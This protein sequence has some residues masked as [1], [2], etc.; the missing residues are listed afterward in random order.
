VAIVASYFY[1]SQA[2]TYKWKAVLA[3]HN[4]GENTFNKE[5][6]TL[7]SIKDPRDL[8]HK[9]LA[10]VSLGTSLKFLDYQLPA[11]L[12]AQDLRVVSVSK[13]ID[14]IMALGFKQVEAAIAMRE[15]FERLK[16]INP[17]AVKDLHILQT[18]K[19]VEYPKIVV[20][21]GANDIE[22][23]SR[24]FRNIPYRG[25]TKRV[26][27]FFGVTGFRDETKM[28]SSSLGRIPRPYG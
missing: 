3:G 20:F 8:N 27:I 12:A 5:L 10:T 28:I 15:S 6:V 11:G 23:I 14:A 9:A 19:S 16:K 26:L 22:S 1:S 18:L 4:K 25:S 21:P 7:K 17:V 2:A 13:D 24:T